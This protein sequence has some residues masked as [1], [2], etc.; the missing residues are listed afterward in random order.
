[1]VE[2][3]IFLM[4]AGVKREM[5][6]TKKREYYDYALRHALSFFSNPSSD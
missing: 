5:K 3:K 6:D 4:M 2:T 1:M